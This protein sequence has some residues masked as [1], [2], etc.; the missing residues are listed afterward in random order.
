M[1]CHQLPA[2]SKPDNATGLAQPAS[3]DASFTTANRTAPE[4]GTTAAKASDA[5]GGP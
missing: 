1:E 3:T 5:E 4:S 2:I